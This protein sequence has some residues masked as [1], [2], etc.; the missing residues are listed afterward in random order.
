[1]DALMVQYE[2]EADKYEVWD[3]SGSNRFAIIDI[4]P[5]GEE[6]VTCDCRICGHSVLSADKALAHFQ[7]IHY[8]KGM[9]HIPAMRTSK[10]IKGEF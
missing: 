8:K 7:D 6:S 10:L 4:V 1:M 2:V 3:V 9:P 5:F